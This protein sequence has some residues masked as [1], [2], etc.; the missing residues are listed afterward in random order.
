MRI[1]T[2]RDIDG[3][4]WYVRNGNIDLLGNQSDVFS[5]ARLEIPVSIQADPE[6]AASVVEAAMQDAVTRP[7]IKDKLVGE[8]T[9]LGIS[10]FDPECATLRVMVNTL[11]GEQWG[12]SRFMTAVIL[13]ALHTHGVPLPGTEPTYIRHLDRTPGGENTDA[14]QQ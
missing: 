13:E 5:V 4:L 7:E 9:M 8:A 11:P 6:Q 14:D 2:V 1:T 12:V 3:T 10:K